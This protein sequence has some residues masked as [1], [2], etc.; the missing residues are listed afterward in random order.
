[1]DFPRNLYISP[2]E[3]KTNNEKTYDTVLVEN[4]EELKAAV[5]AGYID[6][7]YDAL[8]GTK[9]AIEAEKKKNPFKRVKKEIE[10]DDF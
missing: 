9:E 1:M 2:G 8:H 3:I 5:K 4:E 7:Y 6:S 10:E